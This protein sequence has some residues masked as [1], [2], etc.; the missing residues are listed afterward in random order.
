MFSQTTTDAAN[1]AVRIGLR[2]V[3]QPVILYH[4][5]PFLVFLLLKAGTS[6]IRD[7][8]IIDHRIRRIERPF[9]LAA[10]LCPAASP[11]SCGQL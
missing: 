11:K 4:E 8:I 1:P 6:K 9:F 10:K 5:L 2:K 7:F 3:M